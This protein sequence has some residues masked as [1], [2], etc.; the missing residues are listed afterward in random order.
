MYVSSSQIGPYIRPVDRKLPC[1][2]AERWGRMPSTA[3]C[4]VL[5]LGCAPSLGR[6]VPSRPLRFLLLSFVLEAAELFPA[7]TKLAVLPK[8]LRKA[9]ILRA[10]QQKVKLY[11]QILQWQFVAAGSVGGDKLV[12]S[13]GLD[14]P[15]ALTPVA[16]G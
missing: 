7:P 4:S 10:R 11:L 6:L 2:G 13:A 15:V 14:R 5:G 1:Q 8:E 16:V 3:P 9:R 12:R